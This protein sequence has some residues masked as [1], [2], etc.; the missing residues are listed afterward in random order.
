MSIENLRNQPQYKTII[1]IW[2]NRTN[3]TAWQTF[4]PLADGPRNGQRSY[5]FTFWYLQLSSILLFLSLMVQNYHPLTIQTDIGEDLKVPQTQTT[6]HDR[7]APFIS[8]IKRVHNTQQ[9]LASGREANCV[10]LCHA[11]SAKNKGTSVQ[12]ATGG[13]VLAHVSWYIIPNC[14]SE[15]HLTLNWKRGAHRHE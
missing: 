14:I 9:T 4:T 5:F 6:R 8:Q 15:N 3:L 1:E 10:P 7:Q 12:N 11:C 2:H 13:C